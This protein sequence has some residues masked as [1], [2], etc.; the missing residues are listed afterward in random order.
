[1]LGLNSFS[2]VV[3]DWAKSGKDS[4][5]NALCESYKIAVDT[6][7][8]SF[9]T[10]YFQDSMTFDTCV[11]YTV[12][13]SGFVAKYN[14]SGG[15]VWAKSIGGLGSRV[16]DVAT[17]V[18]GNV[19]IVGNFTGT[20]IVDSY[21]FT[22]SLSDGFLIK[23]DPLGN[24]LWAKT[25]D[26]DN[27]RGIATD[28]MGNLLM[29]GVFTTPTLVIDTVT[30]VSSGYEDIY[31]AKFDSNGNMVWVKHPSGNWDDDIRSIT[32]DDFGNT[33]IS[34]STSS[35]PLNF[36]GASVTCTTGLPN[37]YLTKFNT[38][39]NVVWAKT[40]TVNIASS[41]LVTPFVLA[42]NHL[43]KVIVTGNLSINAQP[44][45][46][47]SFGSITLSVSGFS[48]SGGCFVVQYDSTGAE[49]WGR[50]STQTS[51][52][53]S[54]VAS[55][56]YGNVYVSGGFSDSSI[57][58]DSVTLPIQ[59]GIDDMFVY[60]FNTLGNVIWAQ[61]FAGGGDD[62]NDI[63]VNDCDVYI[64]GDF[65][66]NPFV[67]GNDS[68]LLNSREEPFITMFH[69]GQCSFGISE[70]SNPQTT[71]NIA[72]NPFTSQT[73]I[74][75][76]EAQTNTTIKIRDVLG[77]TVN[78]LKASGKSITLDMSGVAKGI[79]FVEITDGSANSPTVRNV[80]NKKIIIQ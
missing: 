15:I 69:F 72:P 30:I 50:C 62:A 1:M 53:G 20:I 51:S 31:L 73:T 63:A 40:N 47:T 54:G 25:F 75:F 2:Q 17:D 70:F 67:I 38:L 60:K 64:G 11:I 41:G 57:T 33:Y 66:V 35:T 68:L 52:F 43:G 74:S 24:V 32:T 7:G 78:S 27:I 37:Y 46:T 49:E 18:N 14:L 61:S 42:T 19:Y 77:N 71:V 48:A 26:T 76:S 39:G 44:V 21:T 4:D 8:N 3:W 36:G 29:A 9:I 28:N 55:D 6:Y 12:S 5:T 79:Y 65:A 22:A 59:S 58:I 56:D 34:G 45:A 10:G 13:S 16:S 80:V 23:Y